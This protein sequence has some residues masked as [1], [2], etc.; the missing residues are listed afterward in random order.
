MDRNTY[1]S[2]AS[3]NNK[4]ISRNSNNKTTTTNAVGFAKVATSSLV[5]E[6]TDEEKAKKKEQR[7]AQKAARKKNR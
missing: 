4:N 3:R 5:P 7:K 6:L 1:L 2:R